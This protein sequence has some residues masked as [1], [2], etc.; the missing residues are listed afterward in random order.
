MTFYTDKP[1][2]K[3]Y[4]LNRIIQ[5]INKDNIATNTTEGTEIEQQTQAN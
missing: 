1:N 2:E 5:Q 4:V 3:Q